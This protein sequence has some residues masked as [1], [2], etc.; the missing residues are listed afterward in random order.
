MLSLDIE[1]SIFSSRMFNMAGLEID[2]KTHEIISHGQIFFGGDF[3][4]K[5]ENDTAKLFIQNVRNGEPTKTI[6]L[7]GQTDRSIRIETNKINP[8]YKTQKPR[9]ISRFEY[10]EKLNIQNGVY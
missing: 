3:I 5:Y 6:D 8:R 4:V 1:D 10:F 9:I 7:K 2:K